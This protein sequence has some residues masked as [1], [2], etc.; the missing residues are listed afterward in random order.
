MEAVDS[1]DSVALCI[2]CIKPDPLQV[3]FYGSLA[4]NM[5]SILYVTV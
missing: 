2:I 1:V 5:M 3:V 4:D